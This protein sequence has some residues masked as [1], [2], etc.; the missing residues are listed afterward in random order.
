MTRTFIHRYEPANESPAGDEVEL[1]IQEIEAA[2]YQE[3]LQTS[4]ARLTSWSILDALLQDGVVPFI[5]KQPLGIAREVKVAASGLFGRF[6]ARAYLTRYKG[7][8]FYGHLG[9]KKITL[10]SKQ[11]LEIARKQNGDLPDW[12]ACS[13]G[14]RDLTVAEAKR[15]SNPSGTRLAPDFRRHRTRS[16]RGH[17]QGRPD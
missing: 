10:D 14:L 6:I 15:Y 5:F 13:A 16:P 2:G 3:M 12:V 7:L 11:V 1:T 17:H 9:T 4:G 8:S